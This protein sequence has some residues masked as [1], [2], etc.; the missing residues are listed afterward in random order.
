MAVCIDA[1]SFRNT[2]ETTCHHLPCTINANGKA[3]VADFFETAIRIEN[4]GE[5]MLAKQ[6]MVL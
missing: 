3:N 1:A 5:R 4:E 6:Q 2:G